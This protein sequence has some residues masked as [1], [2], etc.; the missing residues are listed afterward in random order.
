MDSVELVEFIREKTGLYLSDG[1]EYGENGRP[2]IRMNVA[3]PKL[4]LE[5]GLARFKAG[6]EA[7]KQR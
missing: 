3:C 2:F 6:I 4:R 7:Y 1:A 5:D